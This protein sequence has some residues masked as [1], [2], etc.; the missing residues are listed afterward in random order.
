MADK[1]SF[2]SH[3]MAMEPTQP[4]SK[5]L[6]NQSPGATYVKLFNLSKPQFHHPMLPP[7]RDSKSSCLTELLG[8]QMR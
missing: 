2:E 7:D 4:G 3:R 1:H 8:G 5:S 6:S